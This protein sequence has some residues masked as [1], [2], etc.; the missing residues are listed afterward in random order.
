M[1]ISIIPFKLLREMERRKS[2]FNFSAFSF[3]EAQRKCPINILS[4]S[5]KIHPFNHPSR[6]VALN[7][8][9]K[10]KPNKQSNKRKRETHKRLIHN[11]SIDCSIQSPPNGFYELQTKEI[12]TPC[13][14]KLVAFKRE[15]SFYL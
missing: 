15:E 13:E 12:D 7:G 4:V 5:I 11:I 6:Q 2:E 3:L 14:C 10:A 1:S 9:Q 8:R